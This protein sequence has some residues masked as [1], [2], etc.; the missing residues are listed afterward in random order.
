MDII[1]FGAAFLAGILTILS[2]C[3]LPL[4]PIIFGAAVHQHPK[5]PL[6]I[7]AGLAIG[8]TTIGLFIATIG[9]NA[10]LD[11]SLFRNG[12][13]L[14]LIL[15]GLFLAVPFAQAGLQKVLAPIGHWASAKSQRVKPTG[16][17]G[18]FGLGVLLGAV[19][20]PCVGPTLG[21]AA[22]LAARGEQ[23]HLV[24]LTMAVFGI[25]AALPLLVIG[26]MGRTLIAKGRMKL[27]L[28]G[29]AGKLFLG[30]GM[31]AAGLLVLFGF[32][33]QIEI[34]MLNNG[35]AIFVDLSTRF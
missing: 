25:G 23:L 13:A 26:T 7:A 35:P 5:A 11:P 3:V 14:L 34:W 18:Q 28:A 8:F 2:P 32:D 27:A 21:A 9:F 1:S 20:S 24:A 19:W 30:G 31:I 15:F 6:M 33:K 12:S 17:S 4:L 22:L 16:L 29:R 10:G